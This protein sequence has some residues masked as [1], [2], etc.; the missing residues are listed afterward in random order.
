MIVSLVSLS[1]SSRTDS[2]KNVIVTQ[3]ETVLFYTFVDFLKVEIVFSLPTIDKTV[4]IITP[5]KSRRIL[6]TAEAW[7]RESDSANKGWEFIWF[8]VLKV[9]KKHTCVIICLYTLLHSLISDHSHMASNVLVLQNTWLS[10]LIN[11]ISNSLLF[12]FVWIYLSCI[13]R[14][15]SIAKITL[16]LPVKALRHKRKVYKLYYGMNKK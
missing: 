9:L 11:Y 7:K 3:A 1:F 5:Y 12:Y 4:P 10:I 8:H 13:F 14:C 2:P 15:Y 6:F 16:F